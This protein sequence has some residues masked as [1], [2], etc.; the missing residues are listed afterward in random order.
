ML[1]SIVAIPAFLIRNLANNWFVPF[2]AINVSTY[3]NSGELL[4]TKPFID[5]I[6]EDLIPSDAKY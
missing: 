3:W 1:F 2:D 6:H 4:L 5:I